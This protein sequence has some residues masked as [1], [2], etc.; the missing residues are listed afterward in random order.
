MI[1]ATAMVG[2]RRRRRA[3]FAALLAASVAGGVAAWL[4]VGRSPWPTR[5]VL[6]D[7]GPSDPL[8][9]SPD[10]G[11][12]AS[13]GPGGITLW[14]VT[15][16]RRR[17]DWK[18]ADG[19][20]DARPAEVVEATFSPDGQDLIILYREAG[21][22]AAILVDRVDSASGVVRATMETGL[23]AAGPGLHAFHRE[24]QVFRLI[25]RR[26][27]PGPTGFEVVDLDL[28]GGEARP[29]R[30]LALPPSALPL[31]LSAEGR[32]LA[33]ARPGDGPEADGP[34]LVD[35][36]LWGVDQDR[37][38]SRLSAPGTVA[39][40]SGAFSADGSTLAVGRQDGAIELWDVTK[41]ARRSTFRERSA[42][43]APTLLRFAPDGSSLASS[44]DHE[45]LDGSEGESI[46]FDPTDGRVLGRAPGEVRPAIGPHG[47]VLAT[48]SRRS[49][50][51]VLRKLPGKAEKPDPTGRRHTPWF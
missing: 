27:G 17:D 25:L 50:A 20:L 37:E 32:Y 4:A 1:R 8:D 45:G 39:I 29:G 12:L 21:R 18:L 14:D 2:A 42:G 13:A 30:P 28:M 46:V 6:R 19:R 15:K 24:G 16:G 35:V 11:T 31:A 26:P 38:V 23:E 49:G 43:F 34:D 51:V 22:G 33:F 41:G 9:F 10:G 44:W 36:S 47:D 40:R 7:S 3:I 5:A 48:G